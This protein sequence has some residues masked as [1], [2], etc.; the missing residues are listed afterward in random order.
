VAKEITKHFSHIKIEIGILDLGCSGGPDNIFIELHKAGISIKYHGYDFNDEEIKRLRNIFPNNFDFHSKKIMTNQQIEID[1]NWFQ[2]SSAGQASAEAQVD[3]YT[4]KQIVDNNF[5]NSSLVEKSKDEIKIQEILQFTK[6]NF[7]VLKID[8]DGPDFSYLQDYFSNANH[9]PQFVSLEINYQGSGNSNSNTFHNTD[10][11]MKNLGYNLV[12][13]TSRTYSN[14]ALPSRFQY[15]IFA[16]TVKGIPLQGDALYLKLNKYVFVEEI[17]RDILILDAFNLEDQAAKLILENYSLIG[18]K[19]SNLM[20]NLLTKEVW[21]DTFE[22]YDSLIKM[23]KANKLFF[24][25]KVINSPPESERDLSHLRIKQIIK[26]LI[27]RLYKK[28]S[29]RNQKKYI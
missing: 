12:A 7:D 16:Q 1:G 14:K 15:N 10:R 22:S 24:H 28:F 29:N 18:E 3:S 25:P 23:W 26:V 9:L 19:E 6:V 11:Y 8:L 5:W 2:E 13:I 4:E 21:G 20:L 27:F 17:L